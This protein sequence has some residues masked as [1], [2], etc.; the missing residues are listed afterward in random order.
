MYFII[1]IV[2]INAHNIQMQIIIFAHLLL[3]SQQNFSDVFSL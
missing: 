1:I 3:G 2:I